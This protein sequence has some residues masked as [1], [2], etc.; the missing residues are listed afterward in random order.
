MSVLVTGASGKLG[1][2]VVTRLVEQGRAVTAWSGSRTGRVAGVPLMRVDLTD[3]DA[4]QNAFEEAAPTQVVHCAALSAIG[5]CFKD[6]ELANLINHRATALLSQLAPRMVYTST[7][8]VFD[9]T[10]PPYDEESKPVPLS[11]Y[12]SSKRMGETAC[13]EFPN[14]C[15]ARMSLLYGKVL[16]GDGVS[17]FFEQQIEAL[18]QGRTLKLFVDEFRTPLALDEA[19]DGLVRLL[20]SGSTGIF[21]LAGPHT[22]SRYQMGRELADFLKA[23]P[24]LM[25]RVYQKSLSFPE[26]RPSDVSLSCKRA[27][28]EVGWE[29]SLYSEGLARVIGTRQDSRPEHKRA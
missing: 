16:F 19:A 5:D 9:G 6:P 24:G 8:L 26:P 20:D 2:Y 27:K 23:D 29:P 13:L 22:V 14:T 17:G 3:L 21:H 10:S 18:T 4:V 7:D 1:A 28:R 15:V 25:E 12:G 11:I